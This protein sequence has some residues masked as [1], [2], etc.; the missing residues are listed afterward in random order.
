MM[1]LFEADE[2]ITYIENNIIYSLE[3]KCVL[4]LMLNIN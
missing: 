3:I 4:I 2:L 1:I